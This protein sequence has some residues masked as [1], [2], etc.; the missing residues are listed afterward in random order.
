VALIDGLVAGIISL[1]IGAVAIHLGARVVIDRDVDFGRAVFTA[2]VGAIAWALLGFVQIIPILGPLL[3]LIIW[4]GIINWQYP[5]GWGA[6][7][8]IGFVAW[9]V[10]LVVTYLLGI[11]GV[12]S[13]RALGVP[14][15]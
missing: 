6:A 1:I 14:G 5:G 7:A 10:A 2:A 3:M 9:I 8:A 11:L 12:V 4:I 15:A 13:L